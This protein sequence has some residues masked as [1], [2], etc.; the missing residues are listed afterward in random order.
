MK[1]IALYVKTHKKT[2]LKYLGKTTADP[3]NYTGSGTYWKRHLKKHGSDVDT[4]VIRWCTTESI[5]YWGIYYSNLYNVVADRK[6]A[7]LKQ[8][9]GDGGWDYIHSTG[10]N[11]YPRKGNE[12][13]LKSLQKAQEILKDLK[14]NAEWA[15]NFSKSVSDGVNNY[16]DNGGKG[17]FTGKKHKTETINKMHDTH[18]INKHQQGEKNSQHGTMWINN[19]IANTKWGKH[20]P[21]PY[22]W[23]HGRNMSLRSLSKEEKLA[24]QSISDK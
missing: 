6:W 3:Y 13:V 2:G 1:I 20:E 12:R 10:R 17:S 4:E 16:Y 21:L 23:Q 8:E 22:G 7:N 24:L 11:R 19:N 5:E 18:V 9:Q 15:H 14:K